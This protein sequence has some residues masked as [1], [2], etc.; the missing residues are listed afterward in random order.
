[1][2]RKTLNFPT[3]RLSPIQFT[4]P[5][6]HDLLQALFLSSSARPSRSFK[7]RALSKPSLRIFVDLCMQIYIE[8]NESNERLFVKQKW[9]MP[10]A[11]SIKIYIGTNNEERVSARETLFILRMNQRT[12][13]RRRVMTKWFP[14]ELV[15]KIRIVAKHFQLKTLNDSLE[16]LQLTW[17]FIVLDRRKRVAL[18]INVRGKRRR[19]IVGN[20]LVDCKL[21]TKRFTLNDFAV[22]HISRL[23]GPRRSQDE[24]QLQQVPFKS[25]TM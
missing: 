19:W 16:R 17:Q 7:P 21:H 2:R 15:C 22:D 11:S 25:L 5:L 9:N 20:F 13:H 18:S 10:G 4:F 12:N 8:W 6:H 1:M 23:S 3:L 24:I 14:W